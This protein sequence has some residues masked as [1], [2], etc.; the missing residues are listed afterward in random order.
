MLDYTLYRYFYYVTREDTD[1]SIILR[2]VTTMCDIKSIKK[3]TKI[4]TVFLSAFGRVAIYY[5]R[6]SSDIGILPRR[7]PDIVLRMSIS[8]E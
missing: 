4:D 5:T 7:D 3:G 6:E 8:I 1:S 2:T